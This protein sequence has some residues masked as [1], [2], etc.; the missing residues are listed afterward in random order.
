MD[1][2]EKKLNIGADLKGDLPY[3]IPSILIPNF[4]QTTEPLP[5]AKCSCRNRGIFSFALS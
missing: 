3:T 4:P 5:L 1:K 2:N